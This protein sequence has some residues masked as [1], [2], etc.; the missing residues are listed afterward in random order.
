MRM[1]AIMESGKPTVLE[2]EGSRVEIIAG[3]GKITQGIATQ[4][5]GADREQFRLGMQM[6]MSDDSPVWEPPEGITIDLSQLLRE[7]ESGL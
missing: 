7:K 2:A 4:M 5:R 3:I 6:V 1:R